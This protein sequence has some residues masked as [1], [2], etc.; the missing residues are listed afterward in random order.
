MEDGLITY[1]HWITVRS[2]M[3]FSRIF[4]FIIVSDFIPHLPNL[5]I[6]ED[7]VNFAMLMN[8]A[9]LVLVVTPSRYSSPCPV[10]FQDPVYELPRQ[11]SR[12]MRRWAQA[13]FAL[14]L[15]P[16]IDDGYED[17]T[18]LE[19]LMLRS[20]LGQAHTLWDL[21]KKRHKLG[22]IGAKASKGGEDKNITPSQVARAIG[23]DLTEFPG[24]TTWADEVANPVP[25]SYSWPAPPES[26][27]YVMKRK[28]C[29]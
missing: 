4:V 7:F 16:P 26:S 23:Q 14:V 10:S 25:T 21:I 19:E 17:E 18:R 13:H 1:K 15:D 5:L 29:L 24:F 6:F 11:R 20:L 2:L 27:R 12:E 3:L 9:E 22:V 8:Y 28:S